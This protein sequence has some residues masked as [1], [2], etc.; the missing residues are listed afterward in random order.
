MFAQ[1]GVRCRGYSCTRV[2]NFWQQYRSATPSF[3]AQS[4][5]DRHLERIVV[6]YAVNHVLRQAL[7]IGWNEIAS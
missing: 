2:A 3:N 1:E 4:L 5:F 7:R 6:G